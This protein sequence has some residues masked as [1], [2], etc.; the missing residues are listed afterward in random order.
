MSTTMNLEPKLEK[1]QHTTA[2]PGRTI[3]LLAN[4]YDSDETRLLLTPET[5]GRLIMNGWEIN[6]ETE[7]AT[8][9]LSTSQLILIDTI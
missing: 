9:I 2:K 8:T 4:N 7:A 3:G 6:M 5:C 1:V